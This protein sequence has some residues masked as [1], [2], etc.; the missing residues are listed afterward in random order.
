M[1]DEKQEER[2]YKL[3]MQRIEAFANTLTPEGSASNWRISQH[4]CSPRYG[5]PAGIAALDL[6]HEATNDRN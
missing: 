3:T 1:I 6:A 5:K 4:R 2:I